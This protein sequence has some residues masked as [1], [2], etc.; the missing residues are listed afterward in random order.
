[1]V[2]SPALFQRTALDRGAKTVTA[3]V[4]PLALHPYAAALQSPGG[5]ERYS[6][7]TWACEVPASARLAPRQVSA[8]RAARR[9]VRLAEGWL[10]DERCSG[11]F[12]GEDLISRNREWLRNP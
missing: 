7:V 1:V 2:P 5:A 9:D 4:S 10:G 8:Q 3:P 6:S 12:M 11:W